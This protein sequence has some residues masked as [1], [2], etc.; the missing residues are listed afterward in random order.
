MLPV[1]R[2]L[3]FIT[4]LEL[5]GTPTVVRELATRL[6]PF[7]SIEVASLKADGA[8]SEDLRACGFKVH[9][10]NVRRITELR[11]AVSGLI[12]LVKKGEFE[13]LFSF[14]I[15]ANFVASRAARALKTLRCL[16]SIQTTQVRPRWHWWIQSRIHAAAARIIVPSES[17]ATR[18]VERARVPR[19][20]IIVIPN[21]IDAQRFADVQ[22]SPAKDGEFRVGFVGRLDPIKSIPDL[23]SSIAL[24]PANARLSIFGEGAMRGTLTELIARLGVADR[25][26]LRGAIRDPR[27]AYKE[28]DALVLPSQSEGFG[29]VLIEAMA[30]G[31]PVIGTDVDGIRDVVSGGQNGLLVEHGK[32]DQI[33][34]AVNRIMTEPALRNS[35]VA[36]AKHEVASRFAWPPVIE[37][38]RDVLQL[39]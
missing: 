23:I 32:P 7:A 5:G 17:V 4:D 20:K 29:L 2:L 24:L 28:I 8:V 39:A 1:R 3:F 31:I 16:Q 10:L 13:T 33:A 34:S 18:A 25:V 15:H 37:A 38:Y 12:D 6:A 14:L 9:S 19:E 21:A 30:A 36:K 27:E 11:S 35:L 26:T 22:R